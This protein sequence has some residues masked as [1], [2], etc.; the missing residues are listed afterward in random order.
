MQQDLTQGSI[1]RQLIGMAA[2]IG[3]GLLFQTLY[4]LVD[5][6]FVA[7]VGPAALAGVGLAGVVFF[8]VMA[9]SQ[10]VSVGSISLIARQLGARATEAVEVVF[11]QSM[12][13]S[14]GLALLTL[15]LGYSC[16]GAAVQAIAADPE[17]ARQ[18]TAYLYGFLP[19]MALM[20]PTTAL[21]AALRAA[22]VVKPTMLVQAGS[23]LL[24]AVLAPMLIVGWVTGRPFGAFGAGL[25]TSLAAAVS[26]AA[27]LLLFG[28]V[29]TLLRQPLKLPRPDFG[30][31]RRIVGIGLPSA[32]EFGLMF[33][34]TSVTYALIRT[35]GGEAQAGFGVG[36]RV[37]QAVFLPAMAVAF[38]VAPIAGQNFGAGL[39]NRVQATVRT[40]VV[41]S[42]GLMLMLTIICQWDADWLVRPFAR[43]PAVA[44]I[45]AAYLR[46]VSLNFIATGLIFAASGTFQ[47]LGDTRPALIGGVL[48]MALFVS[49]AAWLVHQ[50]WAQ[51][52][53]IW[54]ASAGAAV[55]HAGVAIVCVRSQLN[56]RLALQAR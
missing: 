23:V 25:A 31:I 24:N 27:A 30:V 33:V 38:A 18:G 5:L 7:S 1:S 47:A 4:Y 36:A 22:G 50:P 9:L 42:S 55:V 43:D 11:R 29:Q 17:T 12:L 16:G 53:H 10:V 15:V 6:Y 34:T 28:R 40:A 56:S 51:L 39:H 49:C 46:I 2:F 3:V 21:G 37:M 44:E 54:W 8:L 45:A 19:A 20:F 48:R 52:E 41:T 13:L 14:A 35:F 32:A 26:F